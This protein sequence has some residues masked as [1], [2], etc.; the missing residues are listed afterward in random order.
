MNLP[1]AGGD[2]RNP[3]KREG[4]MNPLFSAFSAPLRDIQKTVSRR[5]AE[6]AEEKELRDSS[7]F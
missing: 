1:V 5:G 3:D 6:N 4:D 2:F 7:F